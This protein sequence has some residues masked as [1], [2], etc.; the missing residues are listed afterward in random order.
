MRWITVSILITFLFVSASQAQ[1]PAE[2]PPAQAELDPT[3]LGQQWVDRINTLDDWRI[4][5]DGREEGLAEVVDGFLELLTPDVLVEVPPHDENQIGPVMLIGREQVGL[6]AAKFAR[7]HVS[8]VYSLKRQ[9][10]GEVEG[11][12]MVYSKQLP[13]GGLGVSFPIY[14]DYLAR[15]DRRRF[16]EVGA[17]FLQIGDDGK[18][19]RFRIFQTEKEEVIEE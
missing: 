13:W 16:W 15:A 17:V 4:S 11:E 14:L 19:Q 9:T 12:R 3:F 7:S 10:E 18:I 5:M 1:T 8:V 2:P 6:W